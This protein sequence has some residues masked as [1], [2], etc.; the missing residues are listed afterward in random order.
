MP[1]QALDSICLYP[2]DLFFS[3][4]FIKWHSKSLSYSRFSNFIH[5]GSSVSIVLD[6][7]FSKGRM[8]P[9]S[10]IPQSF[11]FWLITFILTP[12]ASMAL[13]LPE[14]LLMILGIISIFLK[15]NPQKTHKFTEYSLRQLAEYNTKSN[16]D[17]PSRCWLGN[18][19]ALY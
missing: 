1:N 11:S 13:S 17:F 5:L 3:T 8:Q 6:E 14:I 16:W 15:I 2:I 7:A 4:F 10:V 12:I 18:H 9:M 19:F